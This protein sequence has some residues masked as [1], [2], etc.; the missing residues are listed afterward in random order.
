MSRG[1]YIWRGGGGVCYVKKW[2][3][4]VSEKEKKE[5]KKKVET[6]KVYI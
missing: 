1:R 4:S 5:G 2:L 3:F 6:W